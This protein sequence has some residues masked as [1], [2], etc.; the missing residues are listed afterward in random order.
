MSAPT[1][2]RHLF[3][4]QRIDSDRVWHTTLVH[5]DQVPHVFPSRMTT[6]AA[7]EELQASRLQ[8]N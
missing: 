1:W 2:S 3:P 4:A 7:F 8:T 6:F 5:A